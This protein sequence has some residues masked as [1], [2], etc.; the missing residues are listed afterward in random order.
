MVKLEQSLHKLEEEKVQ[1]K[2]QLEISAT[3]LEAQLVGDADAKLMTNPEK[4]LKQ[5]CQKRKDLVFEMAD[6]V[7]RS[8]GANLT[9]TI[10]SVCAEDMTMVHPDITDELRGPKDFEGYLTH[11]F[12][13]FPDGTFNFLSCDS[14]DLAGQK[15]KIRF[16][17]TGTHSEAFAGIPA[18]NK[19]V[20][21]YGHCFVTFAGTSLRIQS[22]VWTWN[23]SHFIL[24]LLGVQ[25]IGGDFNEGQAGQV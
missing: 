16:S 7:N 12:K 1:L 2:Q 17:F 13:C 18:S 4:N 8:G 19:Q 14:E 23:A 22:Q 20:T 21:V 10:E 9:E 25:P 24:H 11:L 6:V 15:L 3:V 5:L